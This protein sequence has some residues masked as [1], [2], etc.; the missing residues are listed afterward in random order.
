MIVSIWIENIR[1]NKSK[2]TTNINSTST[3]EVINR[4]KNKITLRI[5][6]NKRRINKN[7]AQINN[8]KRFNNRTTK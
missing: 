3:I 7:K 8:P 2:V 5:T 4:H 1:V 6:S